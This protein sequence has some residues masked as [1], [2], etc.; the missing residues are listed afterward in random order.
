MRYKIVPTLAA[1]AAAIALAPAGATAASA[2]TSGAAPMNCAAPGSPMAL[3]AAEH[4]TAPAHSVMSAAAIA[5]YKARHDTQAAQVRK[6]AAASAAH[7]ARKAA[8][9]RAGTLRAARSGRSSLMAKR[10]GRPGRLGTGV[11]PDTSGPGYAWVDG[12]VQ[13]GQQTSYWCGPATVSEIAWTVPG[14]S[15]VN[16][17]TAA[18]YMGTTQANGTDV[19]AMVNGMNHYVGVPDYG[20]NFYGFVGMDDNP[21]SAQRTYF[22]SNLQSDVSTG[23]PIAGDA[24]EVP[25]GPH[26]IGHPQNQQIFHYF[27]IGGWNT[28]YSTVYYADSATTVWSSVPAYSWEDTYTVETILGGRGYIW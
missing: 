24:W 11:L 15:N 28:N 1:V 7:N 23:T 20:W 22:L 13:Q 18:S 12:L 17:A 4:S 16:Q 14:P 19:G 2:A 5:R 27:E 21:T 10:C 26:L 8:M 3:L 6:A 25:G 9:I